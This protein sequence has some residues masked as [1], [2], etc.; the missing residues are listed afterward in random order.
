MDRPAVRQVPD[1][2]EKQ[3]KIGE[4][5]CEIIRG[6]PTTLAVKGR[7]KVNVKVKVPDFED[8]RETVTHVPVSNDCPSVLKRN[9]S[10]MARNSEETGNHFLPCAA[11]S[12]EFWG[13]GTRPET[14]RPLTAFW[15]P[16]H[17]D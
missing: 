10:N 7:V 5:G 11:R 14:D 17:I 1:G 3:T 15:F 2:S 9:A 8:L 4:T 6:A 13:E 12:F 16:D